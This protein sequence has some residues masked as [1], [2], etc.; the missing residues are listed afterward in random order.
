[1]FRRLAPY[2]VVLAGVGF[3]GCISYFTYLARTSPTH[4]NQV[5]GHIVRMNDHGY[6]F[7]VSPWQNW[8]LNMGLYAWP[9]VS[10]T[11]LGIGRHQKWDL[12]ASACPRWLR[13]VFI[14]ALVA[15]LIYVFYPFP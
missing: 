3:L 14:A 15:C 11:I 13:R 12:T 5:T 7:Y 6:Y 2:L 8:V 1:M 10:I 9:V 4:L